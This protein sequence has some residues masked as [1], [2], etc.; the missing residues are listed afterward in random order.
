M[1]RDLQPTIRNE[2][3]RRALDDAAQRKPSRLGDLLARNSGLPGPRPNVAFAEV[4]GIAIAERPL[5][6][7]D[8]IL[9][10]LAAED[11]APDTSLAFLPI[12]AAYGY[13]ALIRAK[14]NERGAW[15][16]LAELAAD[17]RTPVRVATS[18]ALAQL[19]TRDPRGGDVLVGAMRAWFE[20]EDR[21]IRWGSLATAL[22]ALVERDALTTVRDREALLALAS[23][24]IAQLA[25]APRAA[26]RSDA[27]RRSFASFAVAA[28]AFVRDIHGTVDGATW[29]E[30]ECARAYHPDV[31]R[32]FETA[33]ERLKKRGASERAYVLEALTKALASSAKPP[34]DPTLERKG[35]R[36]RGQ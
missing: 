30:M 20:L 6:E 1:T 34:R 35:T 14:K 17:E 24:W 9:A 33:I 19:A 12:V 3:L 31:R 11:A 16:A 32:S 25:D 15:L 8:A 23:D 28:A 13:T 36:R 4:V 10:P 18:Q 29:L 5:R 27:R 2:D 26:E 7:A 22:D 21:E